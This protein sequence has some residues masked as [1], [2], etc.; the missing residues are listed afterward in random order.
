MG[1]MRELQSGTAVLDFDEHVYHRRMEPNT[2]PTGRGP[3][4]HPERRDEVHRATP[5]RAPLE[6]VPY[7]PDAYRA[8]TKPSRSV[9]LIFAAIVIGCALIA[10]AIFFALDG[11]GSSP[12]AA[13]PVAAPS[14]VPQGGSSEAVDSS[15]C[16]AWRSTKAAL[17]QALDLPRGWNWETPGIDQMIASRNAVLTKAMDLFEPQ[18]ADRPADVATVARA[19]VAARRTEVQKFADR[20]YTGA[21]GVAGTANYTTLNDLCGLPQ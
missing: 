4:L 9:W 20:T 15:T 3:L 7:P 8:A 18:I 21:D 12:S 11:R 10:G 13:P 14:A 17:D 2:P 19:Y 6:Y 5:P 16:R 1:E